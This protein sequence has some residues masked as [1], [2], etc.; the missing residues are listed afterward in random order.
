[1]ITLP[2]LAHLTPAYIANSAATY[3]DPE[4]EDRE[5][6][7][8]EASLKA[9]NDELRTY[10]GIAPY[11]T[12]RAPYLLEIELQECYNESRPLIKSALQ[13]RVEDF[14]NG[15]VSPTAGLSKRKRRNRYGLLEEEMQIQTESL[16]IWQ[17]LKRLFV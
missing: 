15:V 4:W 5:R 11:I 3:R 2:G 13:Q 6:T 1:M 9:I 8:H 7:Y 14:R 12:R 16:G 17:A 10:N